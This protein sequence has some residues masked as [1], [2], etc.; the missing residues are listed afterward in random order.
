MRMRRMLSGGE[1]YYH[2]ISRITGQQFLMNAEEKDVL[3]RSMFNVAIFSGVEILTFALMDN[4]FHILVKV[5]RPHEV[6][7]AELQKKMRVLYGDAKTDR[8]LHDWETWNKRGLS[9]KVET[10]Q[11]ALRLRMFDLSQFCKTLKETYTMSYNFRHLHVGTI[12]GS[13]FKSIL[14]SPDYRT[15]MTVGSYIDL[16]PV[17][18]GAV[19]EASDY[20]WNGYGTAVRGNTL[21]R[22]GLCTMVAMA[23]LKRQVAYETAMTAYESAM[24][25]FIDTP[26]K[27]EPVTSARPAARKKTEK[28]KQTR[29]F[30]SKQVA[31]AIA[32][33]GKL[34][35]FTM[36]RCKVRYFSHGLAVGPAAFVREVIGKLT[37]TK[38][39]ASRCDC[40][41][42][43]ELFTA[44]RL[45][46]DGKVSVPKGRVA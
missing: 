21:S 19:D 28:P 30:V 43:I 9:F 24:Q 25:G 40:C 5:P 8:L 4:H 18:A 2:V 22:N 45:R 34:S 11:E 17:R 36:L 3:M 27:E 46:G 42:E 35:L 7:E 32:E 31:Q 10:A 26:A 41:D 12:W 39:T 20:R 33:G 14:L 16:N 37:P 13:R 38:D 29:T 15:L 44:R 1:G 6:D 23:Y